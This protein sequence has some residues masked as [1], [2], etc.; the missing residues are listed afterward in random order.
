M[1]L[2]SRT[3]RRECARED[4]LHPYC[5]LACFLL[6]AYAY[7]SL[8]PCCTGCCSSSQCGLWRCAGWL[9]CA[10]WQRC[11]GSV[12][13]V[14]R[15]GVSHS[16]HVPMSCSAGCRR[17]ERH[18]ASVWRRHRSRGGRPRPAEHA[19]GRRTARRVIPP[20]APAPAPVPPLLSAAP[21][22]RCSAPQGLRLLCLHACSAFVD[23]QPAEDIAA[24]GVVAVAAE[25][26]ADPRE[27]EEEAGRYPRRTRWRRWRRCS[28]R[29]QSMG[30]TCG[31]R[32]WPPSGAGWAS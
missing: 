27:A 30:A 18:G 19:Y 31:R 29:T 14:R 5:E 17:R 25:E 22:L 21:R 13:P 12:A 7:C 15:H 4:A 11:H 16:P 10:A 28:R 26:Q 6:R 9:A 8:A 20:A 2:G 1:V 32:S 3:R 24:A 23:S